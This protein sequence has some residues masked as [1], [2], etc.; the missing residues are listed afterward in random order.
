MES[1]PF[2][3]L[4][5]LLRSHLTIDE[6]L[7]C[8]RVSKRF[9]FVIENLI[10]YKTFAVYQHSLPINKTWFSTVDERVLSDAN[11]NQ[12]MRVNSDFRETSES[13]LQILFSTML[14]NLRSLYVSTTF[15]LSVEF[16]DGLQHLER[17][18][19]CLSL[20]ED[21]HLAL[22]NLQILDLR[23]PESG[24]SN[25]GK[26]VLD[27][28]KL[29]RLR[30][31]SSK[32]FNHLELRH[33]DSLVYL[34]SPQF[35]NKIKAFA[36][37]LEYLFFDQLKNVDI[38]QQAD[39]I[40]DQF[41]VP[42]TKLKELHFNASIQ[43]FEVISRSLAVLQEKPSRDAPKIY[44]LGVH[45]DRL[46]EHLPN[47]SSTFG[48]SLTCYLWPHQIRLLLSNYSRTARVLPFITQLKYCNLKDE[49][50]PDDF[51]SKFVNLKRFDIADTENPSHLF[52][53]LKHCKNLVHLQANYPSFGQD[54]YN[55]LPQFVP[56]ILTLD[57]SVPHE[58]VRC[59]NFDFIFGFPY[60]HNFRTN[61]YC[62][63]QD[64]T[65]FKL[66]KRSFKELKFLRTFD[67]SAY[68]SGF[69][70]KVYPDYGKYFLKK[71]ENSESFVEFFYN[72][73]QVEFLLYRSSE[74]KGSCTIF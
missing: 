13:K 29:T 37:N 12:R 73:D 2:E 15:P 9:K 48:N 23:T 65:G 69:K 35:H 11:L 63:F 10:N 19:V 4:A 41:L 34:E 53:L 45:F 70:V 46:P 58:R 54:F 32:L 59:L 64:R 1:L 28:K 38:L 3:T 49:R 55:S 20:E 57:I 17:L 72:L 56:Q 50:I 44:L 47:E 42:F 8:R 40:D 43:A 16:L 6:L 25:R 51:A 60:L 33:P 14:G 39:G 71:Y 5:Y 66:V 74:R 36:A 24:G 52:G 7:Q 62:G 30:V 31:K 67:C 27:A 22:P 68:G 21:T 18:R 61:C 26:L